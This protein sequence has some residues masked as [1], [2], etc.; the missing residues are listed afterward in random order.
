MK[1][2]ICLVTKGRIQYLDDAL[3][4][5]ERC[6]KHPWVEILIID[7]GSSA[8]VAERLNAWRGTHIEDVSYLRNDVNNP[9]MNDVWQILGERRTD[10]VVFPG[11]DDIIEADFLENFLLFTKS[12]PEALAYGASVKTM[13]SLGKFSGQVIS[14]AL[15]R[16]DT[17]ESK[18]AGVLHEPPFLWPSLFLNFKELPKYVLNSRFVFDWSTGIMPVLLGQAHATT[19]VSLSYRIHGSQESALASNRRKYFEANLMLTNLITTTYFRDS[20]LALNAN[21]FDLFVKELKSHPPIYGDPL[22]TAGILNSICS[23]ILG[24]NLET[25][26]K[27]IMLGK[28]AASTGVFFKPSEL[29]GFFSLDS[30]DTKSSSNLFLDISTTCCK[31][32]NQ[33]NELTID[34]SYRGRIRVTCFHSQSSSA[35]DVKIDC[36]GFEILSTDEIFDR[37]IEAYSKL[38]ESRGLV[39]KVFSSGEVWVIGRLRVLRK[40]LPTELIATFAK[41]K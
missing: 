2:T 3:A 26:A 19:E 41:R 18:L 21:E 36:R 23:S 28:I 11:D 5:L 27:Q 34:S 13:D 38:L 17:R 32:L 16:W 24:M 37:V 33:M 8:E 22:Y 39:P 7:N 9:R 29:D 12:N 4:G 30:R 10:W 6:L 31:P 1:L 25:K 15:L 20:L 14:P 40:F 35:S